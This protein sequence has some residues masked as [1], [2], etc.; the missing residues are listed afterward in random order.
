MADTQNEDI[1]TDRG[2]V[3]ED[4]H[5]WAPD[6]PGT[7]EAKQSAV[8]GKKKAFEGNDT[9][10]EATGAAIQGGRAFG[11][12]RWRSR[13]ACMAWR[14]PGSDVWLSAESASRLP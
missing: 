2:V 3:D 6:A 4:H 14:S 7:G 9:Q 8:E 5:G 12:R 13:A 1:Q 10:D 11:S